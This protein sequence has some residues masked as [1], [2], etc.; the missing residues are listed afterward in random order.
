MEDC[1]SA[2]CQQSVNVPFNC[3]TNALPIGSLEECSTRCMPDLFRG[4]MVRGSLC[5]WGGVCVC[6]LLLLLL[7]LCSTFIGMCFLLWENKFLNVIF[8]LIGQSVN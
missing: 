2:K 1:L 5:G 4:S 7:W 3:I 8:Y 6:V